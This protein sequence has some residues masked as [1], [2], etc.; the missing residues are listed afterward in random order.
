MLPIVDRPVIQY[1]VDELARDGIESVLLITSAG[2]EA[3]ENHFAA[4]R[5]GG[6]E[7]LFV[8]QPRPLG[9]GDALSY[10]ASFGARDPI[11]V[12]LGDTI[13]A[14][15]PAGPGI[16]RRLADAYERAGACAAVA[17]TPV[18]AREVHRYGIIEGS[19]SADVIDVSGIIEK[20]DPDNV[21]SRLAV[22]ARYILGRRVFE[23][24]EG[25]GPDQSGEIQLTAALSAV[26]ADGGRVVAIKLAPDEQRY[27]IGNAEGYSAA[28]VEHALRDPRFGARLRARAG[29]LTQ[30]NG[31][32]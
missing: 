28:F 11:A 18:T 25:I 16:V 10:A 26:I 2:K 30:R 3:I 15:P 14:P 7:I 13:I 21:S 1:V 19:A 31:S 29:T 9:L 24:L 22:A 5:D 23:A 27:D 20:P 32:R 17:V 4:A 6:P 8:R 12:A